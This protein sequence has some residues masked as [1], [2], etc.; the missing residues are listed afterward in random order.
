MSG[1]AGEGP[2]LD[3]ESWRNGVRGSR[4]AWLGSARTVCP[5]SLTVT[6]YRGL[7]TRRLMGLGCRVPLSCGCPGG[8]LMFIVSF[9]VLRG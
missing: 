8:E 6:V 4:G 3:G 2:G 9:G 7:G 1:G 5:G